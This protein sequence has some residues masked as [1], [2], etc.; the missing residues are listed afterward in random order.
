[1]TDEQS[2]VESPDEVQKRRYFDL[3]WNMSKEQMLKELMRV[4]TASSSL[5]GQAQ[6]TIDD[7]KAV[8]AQYETDG[9]QQKH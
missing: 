3:T 5:L 2:F 7:L 6:A 8:I 4:H 9:Q 1:M